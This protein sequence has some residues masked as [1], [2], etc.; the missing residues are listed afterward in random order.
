LSLRFEVGCDLEEY[1]K[2]QKTSGIHDYLKWVGVT[3]VVY[4]ELGPNE[5]AHIKRDPSHLIVWRE[6]NEIIGHVIWH[7]ERVD[8]FRFPGEE[9][10]RMVLERLLGEKKDFVE[11]HK[12]WLEEKHRGKGY[13]KK[14]FEFFEDYAKKR[15][16]DSIV[17][18]SGNA[19]A[20]NIC[21]KRGYKE[22][23]LSYPEKE[24]WHVFY[25]P[26]K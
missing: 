5:V 15:G 8:G 3:D 6:N 11:L 2:Y 19:S 1:R 10:V 18:F 21:R 17:Y 7:E 22:D 16:F 14:F 20:I 13:G 9:E 12:V 26:L 25:L 23:I 4:G 24:K